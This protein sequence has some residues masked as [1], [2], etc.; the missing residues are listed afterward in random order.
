M[1]EF[2]I[3]TT[4]QDCCFKVEEYAKKDVVEEKMK[5]LDSKLQ[6]KIKASSQS[7]ERNMS[8]ESI[9][10]ISNMRNMSD[11]F[12]DQINAYNK[13]L[14]NYIQKEKSVE[15]LKNFCKDFLKFDYVEVSS[16]DVVKHELNRIIIKTFIKDLKLYLKNY[17][18]LD[19][20]EFKPYIKELNPDSSAELG[21]VDEALT[22][23]ETYNRKYGENE[24]YE[25]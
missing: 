2:K 12:N 21:K 10:L 17:R 16:N 25:V 14:E 9:R 23:I 24:P 19:Y 18:E 11:N 13:K 4:K 5:N 3:D 22:I 15:F 1:A 7:L 6:K 8:N 20:N